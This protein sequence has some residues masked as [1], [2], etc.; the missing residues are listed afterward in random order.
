VRGWTFADGKLIYNLLDDHTVAIDAETGKEVWR[1]KMDNV[2]NGETMT[3]SPF[4]VGNKVLV[5]NSGGEMGKIGWLAALDIGTGKE[6]WRAY[7]AGSDQLD[8]RERAFDGVR[9]TQMLPVLSR[10]VVEGKQRIAVLGQALHRLFVFG[11]PGLDKGVERDQ[12]ILLGLGHPDLLQCD[13]SG[14]GDAGRCRLC[15]G[16]RQDRRDGRGCQRGDW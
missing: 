10:K 16:E 15:R 4:V 13:S 2:E 8:G 14:A 12:R 11:A 1:T 7:C 5:G 3:M 9:R 6:I